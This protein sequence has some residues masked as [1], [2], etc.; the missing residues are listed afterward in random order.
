M[1]LT[2]DQKDKKKIK[3]TAAQFCK[4]KCEK[5]RANLLTRPSNDG[6]QSSC[7]EGQETAQFIPWLLTPD[8]LI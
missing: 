1:D 7:G 5:K 6:S 4:P 3:K 2:S 8:N